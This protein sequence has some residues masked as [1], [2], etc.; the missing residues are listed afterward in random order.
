[1]F[2]VCFAAALSYVKTS[3]SWG[4]HY[5]A[6]R[7]PQPPLC[8]LKILYFYLS[9][10]SAPCF[11]S[12]VSTSGSWPI[13]AW[14]YLLNNIGD[15]LNVHIK[16][17]GYERVDARSLRRAILDFL[18]TKCGG[19]DAILESICLLRQ[20]GHLDLQKSNVFS[21]SIQNVSPVVDPQMRRRQ[22]STPSQENVQLA[23]IFIPTLEVLY[24][25]RFWSWKSSI[26]M[27]NVDKRQVKALS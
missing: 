5:Q 9:L 26:G 22:S 21:A 2:C 17:H 20:H 19:P 8:Q 16:R 11:A 6:V 14:W 15:D 25:T 7:D 18:L 3:I 4:D 13:F 12:C 10:G 27:S 1:M 24:L 23:R